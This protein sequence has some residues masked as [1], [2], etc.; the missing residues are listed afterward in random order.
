VPSVEVRIDRG[1]DAAH[2]GSAGPILRHAKGGKVVGYHHRIAEIKGLETGMTEKLHGQGINTVEDL[3]ARAGPA[4]GRASLARALQV[5][6]S[7]LTEWVN[8]ADLM[9]LK[10]VGTEMAN[11]LEESG[12]DSCKELQHR[13]PEHLH[14]HLKQTNDQK[15]I[16]HHA[17]SL[18]QV[19]AWISEAETFA[20]G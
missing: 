1:T 9:R 3:I 17:P 6:T 12:V 19:Q 13:V 4:T 16:T 8:R 20:A 14:A 2:S 5:E 10:G 7:Q 15:K 18:G 11:L